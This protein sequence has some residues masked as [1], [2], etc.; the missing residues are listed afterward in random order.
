MRDLKLKHYFLF[1]LSFL[2]L[3]FTQ[4]P[5]GSILLVF[6]WQQMALYLWNSEFTKKSQRDCFL[7][8][9]SLIPLFFFLGATTSFVSIYLKEFNWML[10]S[11][12]LVL[13]FMISYIILVLGIS[14]F[15]DINSAPALNSVYVASL[16]K[17]K[18]RKGYFLKLNLF[19]TGVLLFL[20]LPLLQLISTDFTIVAAY[21]L[22]HIMGKNYLKMPEISGAT[23]DQ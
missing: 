8:T 23:A 11:F 21:V 3:L 10:F 4:L 22:T 6:L 17:L 2:L 13:N 1:S 19:F 5:A 15:K 20:N 9:F 7:H 14:F 12:A 18:L 16:Q